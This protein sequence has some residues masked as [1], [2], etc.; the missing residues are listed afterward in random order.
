MAW[1][2]HDHKLLT[3][4]PC[5]RDA[6][7]ACAQRRFVVLLQTSPTCFYVLIYKSRTCK[8]PVEVARCMTS[9]YTLIVPK[10]DKICDHRSRIMSVMR[11]S[12]EA[13]VAQVPE[14][15]TMYAFRV[16]TD[17][18]RCVLPLPQPACARVRC[19]HSIRCCQCQSSQRLS[20]L[21]SSA[22]ALL[23]KR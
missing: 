12:F 7:F 14:D 20:L 13:E 6:A 15:D 11:H 3:S 8:A 5:V 22:A 1:L 10:K 19:S 21:Y 18:T 16:D 17:A 23:C 4:V 9:T 2:L